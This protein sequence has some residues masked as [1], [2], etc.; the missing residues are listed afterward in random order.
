MKTFTL[1]LIA[2]L[3]I[4]FGMSTSAYADR[5]PADLWKHL[6]REYS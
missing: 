4:A 3:G 1:M 6:D 2:A 5:W